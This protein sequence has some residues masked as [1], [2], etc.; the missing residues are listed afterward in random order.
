RRAP[1]RALP[2]SAPRWPPLA[3]RRQRGACRRS[4]PTLASFCARC[5]PLGEDGLAFVEARITA[6]LRTAGREVRILN[7]GFEAQALDPTSEV[8]QLPQLLG[9]RAGVSVTSEV[10][11]LA[12]AE[13]DTHE[14]TPPPYVPPAPLTAHS[15]GSHDA[16]LA[17][18]GGGFFRPIP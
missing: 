1:R 16:S 17:N 6:S 12:E 13:H 5:D 8:P 2:P 18:A 4:S 7:A 11:R 3:D 15:A 10:P 9:D 14:G